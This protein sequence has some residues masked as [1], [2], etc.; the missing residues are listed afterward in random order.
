VALSTSAAVRGD[1]AAEVAHL[2][3][4][5]V[6]FA[7]R[8]ICNL[9]IADQVAKG[10]KSITEIAESTGTDRHML[11]GVLRVLAQ[12]GLFTESEPE[13]F[14]LTSLGDI[15]RT[16]RALSMRH[17]FQLVDHEVAAWAHLD[18]SVRTGEAAFDHV[19]GEGYWEYLAGR[20]DELARRRDNQHA[21][22]RLELMAALRA[23]DWSSVGTV[24]DVGGGDG[25]FL[26]K[27]LARFRSMR[28][29]VFDLPF[30]VE[31]ARQVFV[32]AGV[33][34]RAAVVGG[35]FF[36]SPLPAG[37]DVYVL[38][39]V[40]YAWDDDQAVD[41]LS[42][43]RRAMHG[44]SRIVVIEPVWQEGEALANA[45]LMDLLML[46]MGGGGVRTP[47]ELE[48][49]FSR[50]GLVLTRIIDTPVLPLV[51]GRVR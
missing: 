28:G 17:A 44:E 13:H 47:D 18:H 15:L 6:P 33:A 40:L 42:R 38:K 26:A 31:E 14:E 19:H 46:V 12:A 27:L 41:L 30:A 24:I 25:T 10:P 43:V 36:E 23:Y 5:T 39:R 34:E 1:A 11:L 7:L 3:D 2:V 8:A 9:G 48:D 22:T 51:E 16:D 37:G 49:L 45:I 50:A 29:V 4:P 35:S 32:D 20:P 21:T